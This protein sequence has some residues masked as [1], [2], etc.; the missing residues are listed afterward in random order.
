MQEGD[1]YAWWREGWTR[2][3]APAVVPKEG[4]IIRVGDDSA[5]R[6]RHTS[7]ARVWKAAE[8][9][10]GWMSVSGMGSHFF[11]QHKQDVDE[12]KQMALDPRRAS[13]K[14]KPEAA[15]PEEPEPPMPALPAWEAMRVIGCYRFMGGVIFTELGADGW[16]LISVHQVNK[17]TGNAH[18]PDYSA[19]FKRAWRIEPR[20]RTKRAWQRYLGEYPFEHGFSR[21]YSRLNE[22]LGG[23]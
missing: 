13:S 8:G 15:P 17:V 6:Y 9:A 3:E 22:L 7:G 19:V 5:E 16:E 23:D 2:E 20:L 14:P 4:D 21:E 18:Y 11:G 12:A 1:K 10:W